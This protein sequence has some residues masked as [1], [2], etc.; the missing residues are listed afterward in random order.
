ME[1]CL[2]KIVQNFVLYYVRE[3]L[4]WIYFEMES[5][6]V[7]YTFWIYPQN[8]V[9]INYLDMRVIQFKSI[10]GF[11]IQ[12]ASKL[13]RRFE[14]FASIHS[15]NRKYEEET[16][17]NQNLFFYEKK[18][19]SL[20]PF[21]AIERHFWSLIVLVAQEGITFSF[22]YIMHLIEKSCVIIFLSHHAWFSLLDNKTDQNQ[23]NLHSNLQECPSIYAT[24]C[25]Y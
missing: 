19:L 7:K 8:K 12:C 22:F 18:I 11:W 2:W 13:S 23:M 17:V 9:E 4:S 14:R 24:I 10:S 20:F 16:F 6:V 21:N 15:Q 25:M 3:K 5:T 1:A